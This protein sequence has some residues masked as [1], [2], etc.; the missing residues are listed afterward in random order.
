MVKITFAW[1]IFNWHTYRL[2][3]LQDFFLFIITVKT[4][5]PFAELIQYNRSLILLLTP[6]T[7]ASKS[8]S[9]QENKIKGTLFA[10]FAQNYCHV[11]GK[12]NKL[13]NTLHH[14]TRKWLATAHH[15]IASNKKQHITIIPQDDHP[16]N[17]EICT[18]RRNIMR[19]WFY[20][21]N[22]EK[23]RRFKERYRTSKMYMIILTNL[24]QQFIID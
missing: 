21:I 6:S 14:F 2:S 19:R 5:C 20:G 10:N 23:W 1:F 4:D 15:H 13:N 11:L 17:H 18:I 24:L 9:L 22:K 12:R 3:Q 8:Y 16:I 7:L